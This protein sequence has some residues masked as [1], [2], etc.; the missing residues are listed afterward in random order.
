MP[1]RIRR[2]LVLGAAFGPLDS[3][4][5]CPHFLH[6][7][8]FPLPSDFV[9]DPQTVHSGLASMALLERVRTSIVSTLMTI[10]FLDDALLT[11][12]ETLTES[13]GSR[14]RATRLRSPDGS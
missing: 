13:P 5:L 11:P 10:G 1:G 8:P 7:Y 3:P 14:C 9:R 4:H 6:W 12:P 2:P